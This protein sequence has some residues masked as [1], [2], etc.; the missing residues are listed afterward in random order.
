M[1]QNMDHTGITDITTQ[2]DQ[3]PGRPGSDTGLL[4]ESGGKVTLLV[5]GLLI[6]KGSRGNEP[7]LRVLRNIV[8][9][10]TK[11]RRESD[12]KSEN[13]APQPD[14]AEAL[15]LANEMLELSDNEGDPIIT[16]DHV[17][18]ATA[19]IAAESARV[20]ADELAN[21]LLKRVPIC[22]YCG[23]VDQIQCAKSGGYEG[24]IEYTPYCASCHSD[25]IRTYSREDLIAKLIKE[26][27]A[28]VSDNVGLLD[29][30][31]EQARKLYASAEM[32]SNGSEYFYDT[33][34]E[35]NMISGL[36]QN[37][38]LRLAD[39]PGADLLARLAMAE[40]AAAKGTQAR[41]DASGLE[42]RI[43]DLEERIAKHA[44]EVEGLQA[45]H[46]RLR[47][48]SLKCCF[49]GFNSDSL[50]ML[51]DH[52][53][54]CSKHPLTIKLARFE[55]MGVDGVVDAPFID[56]SCPSSGQAEELLD[57]AHATAPQAAIWYEKV[58]NLEAELAKFR[59]LEGRVGE[60]RP[61]IPDYT[62]GQVFR[63][64]AYHRD[65]IA[66][67]DAQSLALTRA[68]KVLEM[69]DDFAKELEANDPNSPG[70]KY[71]AEKIK[72]TRVAIAQPQQPDYAEP[73]G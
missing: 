56:V 35:A 7:Y 71:H 16:I 21:E 61:K 52:S 60:G 62:K 66:W 55:K 28:A 44:A 25:R 34:N 6:S 24:P 20:A 54:I 49:C 14:I 40:D 29:Y 67:A 65:V 9:L 27:D 19:L 33:L 41:N 2:P 69:W 57:Y 18:V 53:A 64:A 59:A 31:N 63:E 58:G 72:A 68:N 70:L 4:F 32:E 39:H 12:G 5:D 45:A 17:K 51:K 47:R 10:I 46:D 8:A 36:H 3:R 42:A 50:S 11:Q 26:R 38:I 15:R 37:L 1:A 13:P 23:A 48:N 22:E 73:Q 43:W 30:V